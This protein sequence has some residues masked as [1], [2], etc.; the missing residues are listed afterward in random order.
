MSNLPP[1]YYAI[2]VEKYDFVFTLIHNG[3]TPT[4]ALDEYYGT[5]LQFAH[6]WVSNVNHPHE[7]SAIVH[8]LDQVTPSDEYKS[9]YLI[10]MM[11][12]LEE[13][14]IYIEQIVH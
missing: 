13:K 2:M 8:L 7:Y 1:I 3:F 10:N 11:H 12:V 4:F 5:P 9:Q 14:K 6:L